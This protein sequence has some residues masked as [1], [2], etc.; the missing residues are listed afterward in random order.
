MLDDAVAF[1]RLGGTVLM[2]HFGHDVAAT[3]KGDPSNVVT[4]ADLAAEHAI[5]QAI[6]A[7]HPAHSVIAEE[8][9]CD[10][11][12]GEHCWVVDPLDG[13][14]NFAAGIPW[15]G[16]LVALLRHG[17]PI[18]GVL[19][20]PASGELYCATLGGG[21]WRDGVRVAVAREPKLGNVLWAWGM[22][23][24][25]DGAAAERDSARLARV[26]Q[27]VRNVRATNSLV[28]AAYV[29]DGRLGGMT[30]RSTRIWDIAAPMLIVAEAGG[31][32]T[33][34][35]GAPLA[36]DIS[37]AAADRVY[38]VMAASPAL[39]AQMLALMQLPRAA[40]PVAS[41]PPAVG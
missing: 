20:L 16:V 1:A 41:S 40:G 19:H 38:A 2:R 31:V 27:H 39:H 3:R 9:G 37:P 5:V 21:A 35:D 4:Q 22:D 24:A 12:D 15:F 32:F 18:V 8:T 28:D 33:R 36:L 11:R 10:L 29:A 26:L 14:S 6:R 23:A 13:T 17:Q 7:R 25:S 34:D 30:N